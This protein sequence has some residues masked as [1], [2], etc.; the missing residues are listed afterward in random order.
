MAKKIIY[1]DGGLGRV[2]SATG[3]VHR[4]AENH[5]DDLIVVVASWPE[6]F[7]NNPHIHKL[8]PI[9][10]PYLWD[11]VV[12]HGEFIAL[13]P[14]QN[15]HYYQQRHNLA[16]SFNFLLNGE[17]SMPAPE[18]YLTDAE[19]E[20]GKNLRANI[21]KQTETKILG[22]YQ[23]YGAAAKH[24]NDPN[25]DKII[26]AIND[27]SNRS[28]SLPLAMEIAQLDPEVM[29]ANCSTYFLDCKTAAN[30]QYSLRE[31]FSTVHACDFFLG[32]DSS[33]LHIA[34]AF[35]KPGLALIGGTYAQNVSY[36]IFQHL[37]RPGYPKSYPP[38]RFAGFINLNGGAM[39][40]GEDEKTKIKKWLEDIK[41]KILA[42]EK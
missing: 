41:E 11:D 29:Y 15:H 40:F 13:E 16:T 35:A 3:A 36:P 12:Q 32:I 22:A 20:W 26:V 7:H 14:Y 27:E 6:V 25:D 17:E 30:R 42:A 9:N 5:P 2:I 31:L 37:S 38:N 34:A 39:D 33:C 19:K 23:P 28:L 21:E 1:I 8:Y 4:Y 10:H 18:L 24:V